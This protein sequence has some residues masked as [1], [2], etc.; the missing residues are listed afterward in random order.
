MIR[1]IGNRYPR[2]LFCNDGDEP[3]YFKEDVVIPEVVPK[4]PEIPED[5]DM[6]YEE[7]RDIFLSCAGSSVRI[8]AKS[9]VSDR[10]VATWRLAKLLGIDDMIVPAE[11]AEITFEGK[12]LTGIKMPPA[13]GA[14]FS[15]MKRLDALSGYRFSYT[16]SAVRQLTILVMFDFLCGQID[17]HV[18]NIKLL[19]DVDLAE[20][21]P[22]TAENDEIKITGIIA[23]DN[24]LS[25]GQ[26]GYDDIK[27][28]VSA[29]KCIAPE[30]MGEMQ[31]TAVDMKFFERV[32]AV[33]ED[34]YKGVLG[35]LLA[36]SEIAAF[37]DRL[38][39]LKSA[40]LRQQKK[41]QDMAAR[42]EE[43]FSR[44]IT[45]DEEYKK[46]L[47]LMSEHAKNPGDPWDMRFSHRPTYLRKEILR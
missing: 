20:V 19:T 28:R 7:H 22:A 26:N 23:I 6:T 31:Y 16:V 44:F 47:H 9:R 4:R 32:A 40:V 46:Y 27:R 11:R 43:F 25:F 38:E 37:F 13:R 14:A 36:E 29:G 18:K 21:K 42:G 24:D 5:R 3:F 30:F 15:D 33:S 45:T 2:L 10:C 12:T 41:E 39:G 8:P 35:D 17:R 34:E 1:E